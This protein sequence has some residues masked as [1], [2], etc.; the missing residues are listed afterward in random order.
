M[1]SF[2]H[3]QSKY[4]SLSASFGLTGAHCCEMDTLAIIAVME[5][6]LEI[7]RMCSLAMAFKEKAQVDGKG[8]LLELLHLIQKRKRGKKSFT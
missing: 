7:V 2:A 3:I 8:E 5:F 6:C 4:R 1:S